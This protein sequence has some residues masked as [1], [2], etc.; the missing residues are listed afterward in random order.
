MVGVGTKETRVTLGE[1]SESYLEYLRAVST[2][3]VLVAYCLWAFEKAAAA[4]L[5]HHY[6]IPWFQFSI[7][8]FGIAILRYALLVDQGHGGAPE[9]VV[10]GDRILQGVG[11]AWIV[12]FA[13]GLHFG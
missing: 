10:L 3:V 1:Y 11:L 7:V 12:L 5:A 9:D 2:G 6:S 4:Q 13:L 8:P